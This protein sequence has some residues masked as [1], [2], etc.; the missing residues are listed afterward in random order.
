MVTQVS[1]KGYSV[2]EAVDD[3]IDPVMKMK[4]GVGKDLRHKLDSDYP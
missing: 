4:V 2:G 3:M 1:G